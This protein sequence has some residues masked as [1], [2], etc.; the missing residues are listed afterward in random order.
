MIKRTILRPIATFALAAVALLAADTAIIHAAPAVGSDAPDFKLT[1]VEGKTH[2]LSE[3]KGK[4]VVLEWTNPGCPF[5]QKHYGSGNMQK[6]QTE[7]TKKDVVWLSIDSSAQG[8]EGYLT[9]DEGKAWLKETNAQPS[10][11][12]LDADG[13]VG[14]LYGAKATPHIFIINPEGKLLY[15]GAIDS[16]PSA[17][18]ADI[19]KATNYVQTGLD[20]A[21][22]GKAL[23]TTST[24]A[25]GCSV[26]Y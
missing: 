11:L 17:D 10:A 18:K 8:K 12:L 26:K 4:Y 13:K 3:H 7:F 9:A 20:E 1:D 15:A 22:A 2:T 25:Y 19:A 24:K 14:K 5:V 21:M 6:L 16:I 23:T